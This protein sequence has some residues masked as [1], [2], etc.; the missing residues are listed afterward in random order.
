M[1]PCRIGV[2]VCNCGTNIARTVDC[3]RVAARAGECEGV[4]VT[5]SYQY[6]CSTPGQQMIASDIGTQGLTRVVVAACSPRMHEPTFRRALAAGGLNP[7]LLEMANIREQCSWVHEDREAATEKAVALTAAAVRRVVH[8]EPLEKRFVQMCPAT[9]VLGGGIAGLT[10][11]LELA[12]AG[13]PVYL[14][15][16]AY[17]LGG[18]IGRVDLTAPYLDAARDILHERLHRVGAHPHIQV[19]LGTRLA[20]LDGHAGSFTALLRDEATTHRVEVGSVVVCTGYQPFDAARAVEYGYGRLPDVITSFELEDMLR[21]GAVLTHTGAPPRD[22]AIVHCVGS[23]SERFNSYCSRVCCMTALKYGHEIR[24]M[25]PDARVMDLYIDMHA[26][27]KGCEDFYKR[28]SE[29]KTMFLMY[30]KNSPPAIR[31]AAPGEGCGLIIDV[32]EMLSGEDIEIPADLVVLMVGMEARDDAEEVA[33]L[34]NISRDRHGWFIESHPKLDPVATTTDGVYIAGACQSPKDI[35]DS[36]AQARA[37]AARV[38]AR[39][40]RGRIEVDA[41]YAEVDAE[42]CSGCGVCRPMCPYSAIGVDEATGRSY[43]TSAVCKACG[44]CV[45]ACPSGA[46]TGRHFTDTQIDAQLEGVLAWASSPASS[47]SSATG[48]RTP[49]PTSPAR[50]ASATAPI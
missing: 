26:F 2:Y 22:V 12:D 4:V 7:Y 27:G 29:I 33:H 47:G 18:K 5:R 49:A 28:S 24:S 16:C 30:R 34:V 25:L 17:R 38:L 46:I 31:R 35:P 39:I 13:N 19:F 40:T 3:D 32:H 36:V 9:L 10:A 21:R 41:V 6:M 43:V 8:H 44:T 11:A 45:A 20:R 1:E 48:A 37:A 15:E 14:V 23:R 42:A 50:A